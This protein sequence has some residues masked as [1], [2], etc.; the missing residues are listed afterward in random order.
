I[1]QD[2]PNLMVRLWSLGLLSLV[3]L[4]LALPPMPASAAGEVE[5]VVVMQGPFRDQAAKVHAEA[6]GKL[7]R[8][9]GMRP[10]QVVAV[11][12]A[13]ADAVAANYR[14][15]PRVRSVEV[16]RKVRASALPNDPGYAQQW[17][18]PHDGVP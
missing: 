11:D 18:L 12:A 13:K 7:K 14:R 6:G 17:P 4:A 10:A 15:D 1:A 9:A 16:N 3:L 5:L 2:R 8:Q